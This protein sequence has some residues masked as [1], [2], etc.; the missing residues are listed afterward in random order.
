VSIR[1]NSEKVALKKVVNKDWEISQDNFIIEIF[2][3]NVSGN[4]KDLH[5]RIEKES[6]ALDVPKIDTLSFSYSDQTDFRKS[7]PNTSNF[8]CE[9]FVVADDSIYLFTKQ[10]KQKRTAVYVTKNSGNHVA[11]LKE[12]YNIKAYYRRHLC[13]QKIIALSGYSKTLSPFIYLYTIT[14]TAIS[15]PAIKKD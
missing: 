3:N 5:L 6:L 9:A 10:W 4:R 2:G 12:S 8:D 7:K 15:F 13:T 11:Q 14:T 1:C